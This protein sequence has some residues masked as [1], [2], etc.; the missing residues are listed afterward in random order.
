MAD[1]PITDS[2]EEPSTTP[3]P[4]QAPEESKANGTDEGQPTA[5]SPEVTQRRKYRLGDQE[6][7]LDDEEFKKLRATEMVRGAQEALRK[8][9]EAR[10]QAEAMQKQAKEVIRR[11]K[12]QPDWALK[13]AGMTEK[14]LVGFAET[15]LS[16]EMLRQGIDPQT[17]QRLSPEQMEILRLRQERDEKAKKAEE[18]ERYQS[19]QQRDAHKAQIRAQLDREITGA[20]Q[21]GGLPPTDNM[22]GRL[23][24]AYADFDFEV[25]AAELVPLVME[26]FKNEVQHM[27]RA[28]DVKDILQ[29]LPP[30]LLDAL[31]KYDLAAVKKAPQPP[32]GPQVFQGNTSPERQDGRRKRF[33]NPNEAQKELEDWASR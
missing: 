29:I 13:T 14:E 8:A 28:M 26:D 21:S 3:E 33:V 12:D 19:Q 25:P 24:Q 10:K 17:G 23:A 31:R 18:F 20:L 1:Q 22:I 16:Q 5:P 2:F 15:L 7:D 9:A 32:K 30:G 6:L 11:A 27:M 4:Q